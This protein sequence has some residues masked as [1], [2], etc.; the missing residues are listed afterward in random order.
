MVEAF[1][2]RRTQA[3][4]IGRSADEAMC[5]FASPEYLTTRGPHGSNSVSL[6]PQ[7]ELVRT[8]QVQES[9][10]SVTADAP[11]VSRGESTNRMLGTEI[12]F[13]S[14]FFTSKISSNHWTY[15]RCLAPGT[16]RMAEGEAALRRIQGARNTTRVAAPHIKAVRIHRHETSAQQKPRTS[17]SGGCN[18]SCCYNSVYRMQA[19]GRTTAMIVS[20]A[21][22]RDSAWAQGLVNSVYT[23]VRERHHPHTREGGS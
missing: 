13:S 2:T 22:C 4:S 1:F 14:T 3:R 17:L 7:N 9:L 23:L 6:S 15:G 11:C 10:L 19:V 8:S 20:Q 21:F 16:L 5:P 12:S 18:H